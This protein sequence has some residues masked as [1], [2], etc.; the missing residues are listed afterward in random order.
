MLG[1]SQNHTITTLACC[2]LLV[3]YL[4]VQGCKNKKTL[5]QCK[6]SNHFQT[7]DYRLDTIFKLTFHG[8]HLFQ[9]ASIDI[10]KLIWKTQK[11]VQLNKCIVHPK[12]ALLKGQFVLIFAGCEEIDVFRSLLTHLVML[13]RKYNVQHFFQLKKITNLTLSERGEQTRPVPKLRNVGV[14]YYC[15]AYIR[16]F[17]NS[18]KKLFIVSCVLRGSNYLGAYVTS[19]KHL[20]ATLEQSQ[21]NQDRW[22]KRCPLRRVNE[23]AVVGWVNMA[24]AVRSGTKERRQKMWY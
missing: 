24:L 19:Q 17:R 8:L 10:K 20:I 21:Q 23:N 12:A 5:P 1:C 18:I 7:W 4:H 2:G 11:L 3:T 9:P 13:L 6:F 15:S 22:E 14:K 16:S